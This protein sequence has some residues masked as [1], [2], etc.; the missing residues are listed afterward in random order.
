M[1]KEFSITLI[2]IG[3]QGCGKSVALN[4]MINGLIACKEFEIKHRRTIENGSEIAILTI[5]KK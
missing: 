5:E 4:Q 2:A 1:D 3:P